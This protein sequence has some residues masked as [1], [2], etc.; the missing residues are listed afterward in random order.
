MSILFLVDKKKFDI[1]NKKKK[2]EQSI[3]RK[4]KSVVDIFEEK[5]TS[6]RC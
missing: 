1:L 3:V 6:H 4:K 2:S 5:I